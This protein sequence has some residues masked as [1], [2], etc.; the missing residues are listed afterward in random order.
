MENTIQ[1]ALSALLDAL[2]FDQMASDVL[3]EYEDDRLSRYAR[4]V[5]KN[6]HDEAVKRKLTATFRALRLA[7]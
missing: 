2:G 4:V 6:T 1:T 7:A 3:T 5:I